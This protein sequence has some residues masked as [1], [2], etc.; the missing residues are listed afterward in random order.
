MQ[1]EAPVELLAAAARWQHLGAH[2]RA[3]LGRALRRLGWTYGEI[4]ALVPVP[5]GTLAGWCRGITL[6]AEQVSAI[7][8]RSAPRRGQPRDTQRGRR[9]EVARIREQARG[10]ARAHLHDPLFVAG[11]VLYWGEG[12][13]T[14][15]RLAL[16]NADVRTIRLFVRWVERFHDPDARF[17]FALHLH[18]GNDEAAAMRWW[19]DMVGHR[20]MEFTKT[21]VKPAGTGHRKNRLPHG[22]CRVCMRRSADAWHRTMAWIDELAGA[23]DSDERPSRC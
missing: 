22:V 10:S 23:F 1:P 18:E 2:E 4:R 6:S 12:A 7:R 14:K 13:K 15:P 17:V 5:Q 16:A 20:P 9:A 8:R 19:S 11:T 3:E 21:F